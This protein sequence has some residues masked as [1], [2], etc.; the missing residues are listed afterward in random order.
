VSCDGGRLV[1]VGTPIGNLGDLSPRAVEAL[2]AADVIACEDTRV[3]RKLLSHAGIHGRRLVAMHEHNEAS[4]AAR[5]VA[6]A[7]GGATVAVVTDAGLPGISDPGAR[8]VKA[9]VDAG[10]TV[11]VVPGPSSALAALVVS[12]LPTDRFCFEGFLPRK[13]GEKAARL[14]AIAAEP[15]TIVLFESPRRV[16]STVGMLA[17]VCGADRPV[18]VAREMTKVHEEVWRG[19][20]EGAVAW[21][22]SVEPRGEYVLVVGG[23][24][25]PAVDDD[26]VSAALAARLAAGE[27]RK[28]AVASV[29]GALGVPKRRVYDMGLRLRKSDGMTEGSR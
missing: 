26:V 16:R 13:G 28:T 1:L 17:S 12:G 11:D 6:L 21:L 27:D 19:T 29:A 14:A 23:F 5:L 8:L 10:L 7:L 22:S 9:A 4:V 20:L 2:A 18:A 25:A 15:R 24:V 3:T